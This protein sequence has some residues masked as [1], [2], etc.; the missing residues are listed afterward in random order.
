M[1]EEEF[2]AFT[3]DLSG[4]WDGGDGLE[5]QRRIR[6]EWDQ[7][8]EDVDEQRSR[9]R[10]IQIPHFLLTLVP[11]ISTGKHHGRPYAPHSS[12]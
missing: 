10:S 4:H 1:T 8:W 12:S 6:A 11:G 5:Y 7:R 2:Q 9:V 3:D